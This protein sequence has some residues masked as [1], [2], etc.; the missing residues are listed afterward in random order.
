MRSPEVHYNLLGL[1]HIQVEIVVLT[2]H[3]QPA[4]LTP[5]VCLIPVVD[6]TYHSRVIRKLDEEVGAE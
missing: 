2:P 1:L 6:A 4:H 3:G 5:V